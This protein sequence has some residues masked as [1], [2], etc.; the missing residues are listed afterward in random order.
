MRIS[1]DS[2]S[3][4]AYYFYIYDIS[5]INVRRKKKKETGNSFRINLAYKIKQE[6]GLRKSH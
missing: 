2:T 1:Y 6:I 4:Y 5:L 3:H